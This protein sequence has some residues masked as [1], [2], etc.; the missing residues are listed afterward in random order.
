M[1]SDSEHGPATD[2]STAIPEPGRASEQI[3]AEAMYWVDL[4]GPAGSKTRIEAP[5]GERAIEIA[6]RATQARGPDHRLTLGIR[7][8]TYHGDGITAIVTRVGPRTITAPVRS[9]EPLMPRQH[10]VGFMADIQVLHERTN[11]YVLRLRRAFR[12]GAQPAGSAGGSVRPRASPLGRRTA[13]C[14]RSPLLP[15]LCA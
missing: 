2:V 3:D 11:Q 6:E 8:V 9:R 5:N 10:V 12:R 7:Q 14:P 1:R 15:T 13:P 4:I